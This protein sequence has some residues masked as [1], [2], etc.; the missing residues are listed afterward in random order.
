MDSA[1]HRITARTRTFVLQPAAKRPQPEAV[2]VTTFD[3]D[4]NA[5]IMWVAS[6]FWRSL[7]LDPLITSRSSDRPFLPD[8]LQVVYRAGR[9]LGSHL[10]LIV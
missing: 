7:K 6:T 9:S 2:F 8:H 10:D 4:G 1:F 3:R 5:T